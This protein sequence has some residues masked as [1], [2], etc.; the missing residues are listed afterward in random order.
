MAMADDELE[1]NTLDSAS[2]SSRSLT[3]KDD[4]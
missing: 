3:G 1:D 2:D 4:Q